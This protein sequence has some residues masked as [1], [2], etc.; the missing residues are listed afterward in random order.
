M[1]RLAESIIKR[2]TDKMAD[3]YKDTIQELVTIM[4]PI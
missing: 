1:M 3:K 2:T 4:D